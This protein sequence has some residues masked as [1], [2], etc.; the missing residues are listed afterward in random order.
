MLRNPPAIRIRAGECRADWLG[1]IREPGKNSSAQRAQPDFPPPHFLGPQPTP[2]TP[3]PVFRTRPFRPPPSPRYGARNRPFGVKI[4]AATSVS[5][6]SARVIRS[7]RRFAAS[8]AAI[9]SL[10]DS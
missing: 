1:K 5:T 9:N 7:N 4:P 10:L 8:H 2:P 6:R 3:H